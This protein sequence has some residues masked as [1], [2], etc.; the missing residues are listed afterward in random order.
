MAKQAL[1]MQ[2]GK[3]REHKPIEHMKTTINPH[4]GETLELVGGWEMNKPYPLAL[5]YR[6]PKSRCY[7][8]LQNGRL[9]NMGPKIR[10]CRGETLDGEPIATLPELEA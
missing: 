1:A 2:G 8:S 7:W 3:H 9:C 10:N 4:N 5:F 6:G